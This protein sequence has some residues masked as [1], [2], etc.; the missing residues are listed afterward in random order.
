MKAP[1]KACFGVSMEGVGAPGPLAPWRAFF[2]RRERAVGWGFTPLLVSS[3]IAWRRIRQ[4]PAWGMEPR[5]L[6]G[7][8]YRARPSDDC[9]EGGGSKRQPAGTGRG[10][11]VG[12]AFIAHLEPLRSVRN[13]CAP[14]GW[15]DNQIS[16]IRKL[17]EPETGAVR[18]A[19]GIPTSRQ[20]WVN[21]IA[22]FVFGIVS[23]IV[24][25]V[26]VSAF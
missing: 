5:R 24:A 22:G 11:G 1:L 19:L 23:S 3:D 7:A 16:E 6:V 21:R 25:S 8:V 26:I 18:S 10:L 20:I 2:R 12:C 15:L 13:E 17:A 9:S 14:Y 4:A